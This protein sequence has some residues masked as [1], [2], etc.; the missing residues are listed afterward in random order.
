MTRKPKFWTFWILA[1]SLN[2][3]PLVAHGEGTVMEFEDDYV[4]KPA[5]TNGGP[6]ADPVPAAKPAEAPKPAG[7]PASSSGKQIPQIYK[8]LKIDWNAKPLT[9]NGSVSD[10]PPCDD[11]R[12][13][14]PGNK[15]HL[16]KRKVNQVHK[17][18]QAVWQKSNKSRRP[19]PGAPAPE[20]KVAEAPAAAPAS[21]GK[22]LSYAEL[23][24][25]I[26][27]FEVVRDS[28]NIRGTVRIRGSIFKKCADKLL[29]TTGGK[30]DSR[31]PSCSKNAGGFTFTA[32]G[33][34]ETCM[35]T[36]LATKKPCTRGKSDGEYECVYLSED[37]QKRNTTLSMGPLAMGEI[38]IIRLNADGN[39][40]H[41]YSCES[42]P[43]PIEHVT[44]AYVAE[45]SAEEKKQ[46][47]EKQL[48]TA[49]RQAKSCV[50]TTEELALARS[51]C[52]WLTHVGQYSTVEECTKNLDKKEIDILKNLAN[53][54]PVDNLD[55]VTDS[56][57]EWANN[58]P[59]DCSKA[60]DVLQSIAKRQVNRKSTRSDSDGEAGT[61]FDGFNA[62]VDT[63]SRA[64]DEAPCLS[65]DSRFIAMQDNSKANRTLKVCQVGGICSIEC[66]TQ[67][68]DVLQN[69]YRNFADT[70]SSGNW[71]MDNSCMSAARNFQS[72]LTIPQSAQ[73]NMMRQ[74]QATQQL[75]A[76]AMQPQQGSG[77]YGNQ[78][79]GG[80]S[81]FQIP[82]A[83][84][85]M[86]GVGGTSTGTFQIPGSPGLVG[87]T[88]PGSSGFG[89]GV[90]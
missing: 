62:A 28:D 42:F 83:G 37:T 39:E 65:E 71:Q 69:A 20:G 81:T 59:N 56:I 38:Q 64:A 54:G 16:D 2:L 87:N 24:V 46:A 26:K 61:P 21:E 50:R 68:Q 40:E 11:A 47:F 14:G 52:E 19:P 32:L 15:H 1:V 12:L 60:V 49:Q 33:D 73:A 17:C 23:K 84:N 72:A 58:H 63:F 79:G 44:E 7:T 80:V 45:R 75:M 85:G 31:D 67:Y 53:R 76:M 41:K 55:Q 22:D 88:R 3:I 74:A 9:P 78:L 90:L 5:L 30:A 29:I 10:S 89:F 18:E 36:R 66:Q 8:K 35:N 70:C 13:Y 51:A 86:P 43:T 82:G 6:H 57:I 25:L 77:Q 27:D 4:G 34:F 48:E